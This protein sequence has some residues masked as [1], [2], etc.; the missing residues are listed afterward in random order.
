MDSD[1]S[2]LLHRKCCMHTISLN[3]G[4]HFSVEE[5][6]RKYVTPKE[7]PKGHKFEFLRFLDVANVDRLEIQLD[8]IYFDNIKI[9]ANISIYGRE[10]KGLDKSRRA[11]MNKVNLNNMHNEH[12]LR[13]NTHDTKGT[14]TYVEVVAKRPQRTKHTRK[15]KDDKASN[16]DNWNGQVINVQSTVPE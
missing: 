9:N 11:Y 12:L 6:S 10:P 7:N 13:K 15:R 14:A 4:R 2:H 16:E 1:P 5:N 8:Q 3:F